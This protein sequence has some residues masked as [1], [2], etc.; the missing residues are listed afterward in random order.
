MSSS[1]LIFQ[2]PAENDRTMSYHGKY[3]HFREVVQFQFAT[4]ATRVPL[5]RSGSTSLEAAPLSLSTCLSLFEEEGS[6]SL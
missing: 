3:R 5:Y 2:N 4:I 1:V 6:L